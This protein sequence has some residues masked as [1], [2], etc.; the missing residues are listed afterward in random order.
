MKKS[1]AVVSALILCVSVVLTAC[2]KDRIYYDEYGSTH[3]AITEKNGEKKTNEYGYLYEEVTDAEGKARTQIFEFPSVCTNKRGT[4]VENAVMSIEIPK[5][6]KIGGS[7]RKLSL[8]HSGACTEMGV[9]HC[10]INVSYSNMQTVDSFYAEY[11]APVKYL[12]RGTYEAEDLKEYE[13]TLFGKNVK[14]CSY[15]LIKSDITCYCYFFNN[16]IPAIEL[17]AYSYDKCYSEDELKALLEESITLKDLGDDP[18]TTTTAPSTEEAVS[19]T[20]EK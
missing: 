1:I 2:G 12:V 18:V 13:T 14:A 4:F 6:W 7:S 11:I 9:S 15:R 3:C 16:G 5:G 20:T 8:T 17:E 19:T 10:E